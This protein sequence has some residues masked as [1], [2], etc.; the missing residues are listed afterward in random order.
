MGHIASIPLLRSKWK[1]SFFLPCLS[2]LLKLSLSS[3][4]KLFPQPHTVSSYS[5]LVYICATFLLRNIF[6]KTLTSVRGLPTA[7]CLLFSFSLHSSTRHKWNE[8]RL[9]YSHNYFKYQSPHSY[10]KLLYQLIVNVFR[11]W[12][13]HI[14]F[15]NVLHWQGIWSLKNFPHTYPTRIC[16]IPPHETIKLINIKHWWG[17][18][19]I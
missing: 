5:L 15:I 1:C 10:R 9:I 14:I 7:K 6:Q 16:F 19:K 12:S 8:N 13:L 3:A 2:K 17:K 11:F 18:W 4:L